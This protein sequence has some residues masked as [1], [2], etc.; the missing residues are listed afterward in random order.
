MNIFAEK[1]YFHPAGAIK[2]IILVMVFLTAA[3]YQASAL[4]SD[5]LRGN[6]Q[7]TGVSSEANDQTTRSL[8]QEYSINWTKKFTPYLLARAS[9]RYHNLGI[10]QSQSDNIWRYD[11]QPSGELVWQHPDFTM[12]GIIRRQETTSNNDA[13]DLIR[14]NAG[15]T[16]ATKSIKYP[17]LEIRYDWDHT[18]NDKNLSERDTRENRVQGGL[19]YNYRN[20]SLYYNLVYRNNENLSKGIDFSSFQHL[21]RW[22]QSSRFLN[23]KLRISSGYDFTYRSQKTENYGGE[24]IMETIPF[25]RALYAF[26]PTPDLDELDSVSTLGDGNISDPSQPTIDIGEALLDRNIGVDFGLEREV[27]ALYIYTDRPSGTQLDWQVYVSADNLI[28]NRLTSPVF[29]E[30]NSSFNRYEINFNQQTTRYIKAVNSGLND[31]LSVLVTEIQPFIEL[32][33]V[34]RDTKSRTTHTI[35]LSTNYIF[36]KTFESTADINIRTEPAGD[37]GNNRDEIY[38]S[39]TG[40]HRP[41]GKVSQVARYQAGFE[42]FKNGGSRND[43]QALSYSLL[44]SPLPTLAFSFAAISRTDYIERTKTRETNNLFFQAN[45]NILAGLDLSLEAGYGRNNQFDS[46]TKFDNWTYRLSTDAIIHRSLDAIFNVLYQVNENL[47]AGTTRHRRQ[48]NANFNY[49]LT[50]TILLRGSIT[51]DDDENS[52]YLY[53]E[54][55]LSWNMTRR[56]T[57]GALATVN[58]GNDGIRSQRAN[59]RLNYTIGTGSLVFFS[60]TINEYTLADRSET[61][62]IQVGLKSGF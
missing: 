30:F 46:K 31:V 43:N 10:D 45:G 34:E 59:V 5:N 61:S 58:D 1:N 36:S 42:D 27:S 3:H 32:A 56:M 54:Y 47:S 49:R 62:S 52:N 44:Y 21:F 17:L 15:L 55:N 4:F 12:S 29:V 8:N 26:D 38:Y 6:F 25:S 33:E 16:F 20:Q 7:I 24:P 40:R 28:W 14:N 13:T 35:D 23:N 60:Y 19:R 18:Y 57:I 2:V 51:Y 41:S 22:N 53:Q 50:R 48:Y 37:F 39:F 11:Y 9:L